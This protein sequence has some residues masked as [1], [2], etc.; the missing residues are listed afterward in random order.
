MPACLLM[1]RRHEALLLNEF[2]RG[3]RTV[4]PLIPQRH[5]SLRSVYERISRP[6]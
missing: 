2:C 3:S 4:P 1:G 6:S 5:P